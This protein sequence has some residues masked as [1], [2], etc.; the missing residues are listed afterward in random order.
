V[1]I[2]AAG[3]SVPICHGV[4]AT[5]ADC[6]GAGALCLG[7]ITGSSDKTCTVDCDPATQTGCASGAACTFFT[8]RA[9]AMRRLTDCTAPLGTGGQNASCAD[10]TDCQKGFTCI[11]TGTTAA[12]ILQCLHWCRKPAGSECGF[13]VSCRSFGT[14]LIWQ[15][16]EYGVCN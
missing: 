6:S 7:G 9:G 16:T 3:T 11:N 1:N 8:E 13:G 12:P 2:A 10:D 5:D 15:G 4:C 14:P